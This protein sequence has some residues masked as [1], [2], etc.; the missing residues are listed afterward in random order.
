MIVVLIITEHKI[1]VVY[2]KVINKLYIVGMLIMQLVQL[3]VLTN[4]VIM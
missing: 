3:I 1:N 2:L 4:Y